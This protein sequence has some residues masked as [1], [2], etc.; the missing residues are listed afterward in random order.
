MNEEEI[1]LVE[2][3]ALEQATYSID[4]IDCPN[5]IILRS[6]LKKIIEI[7]Y[8]LQQ[9]LTDYKER[10]EKAIE[11]INSE[12]FFVLMNTKRPI[13]EINEKYFKAKNNLLEILDKKDK[14][15]ENEK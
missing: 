6:K 14:V 7:T 15:E 2:E 3:L 12:E 9:E 10:N 1:K 11:Y 8:R 13:Q 5:M 4:A